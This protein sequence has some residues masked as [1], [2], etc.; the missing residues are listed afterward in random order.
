LQAA[1]AAGYATALGNETDPVTQAFVG[2]RRL[3][4]ADAE[5]A[6]APEP[7]VAPSP[8]PA[9]QQ[10]VPPPQA[11][12]ADALWA[13]IFAVHPADQTSVIEQEISRTVRG[14]AFRRP[15]PTSSPRS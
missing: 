6:G 13:Q 8:P 7:A 2:R 1:Q 12:G 15:P 5:A 11:Q 4:L 3:L 9:V 10:H 14:A